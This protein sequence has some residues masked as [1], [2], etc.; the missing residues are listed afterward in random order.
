MKELLFPV[1]LVPATCTGMAEEDL[2]RGGGGIFC[3][4][5]SDSPEVFEDVDEVD[6]DRM[7]LL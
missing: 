3:L 4:S 6:F 2:A 5:L 1:P 7:T